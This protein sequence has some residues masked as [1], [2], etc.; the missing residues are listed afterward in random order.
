MMRVLTIAGWEFSK[1]IGSRSFLVATL[2]SPLLFAAI[3]IIPSLYYQ[4]SAASGSRI[5]VVEFD[6]THYFHKLKGHLTSDSSDA[7][8]ILLVLIKLDTSSAIGADIQYLDSLKQQMDSLVAAYEAVNARRRNI[9][10][11]SASRTKRNQLESSY[12]ELI[13]TRE[14]RDLAEIDYQRWKVRIDSMTRAALLQRADELLDSRAVEAYIVIENDRFEKG[15]IEYHSAQPVQFLRAEPLKHALQ[16]MLVE[17]RME[18][19]EMTTSRIEEL[20]KPV[21]IQQIYTEGSVKQEFRFLQT[22]L[23]PLIVV[24]C[25]FL[26]LLTVT[27]FL[28]DSVIVEKN[29][30]ISDFT[31][32]AATIGQ[33]F[34]G[35]LTGMGILGICQILLWM[36]IVLL[37]LASGIIPANEILFLN[38]NNAGIF[39]GYFILAYLLFGALALA[40]AS[41]S[42]TVHDSHQLNQWMR[43]LLLFPLAL[44]L[45]VI[46][47]PDALLTRLLSFIPPFT[48]TFMILRTPLNRPEALDY[49]LSAGILLIAAIVVMLLAVKVFKKGLI[50]HHT[51]KPIQALVHLV[52]SG[53]R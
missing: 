5:G 53:L 38:F 11:R 10:Q 36:L 23:A 40:I 13:T 26:S 45:L 46:Q 1:Y 22:Y 47:Y 16:V 3:L 29:Q 14:K 51:D 31:L 39:L 52:R 42:T 24:T 7:A 30:R 37:L 25:L 6:S 43:Y 44:G 41:L 34:G 8:Q 33:I 27:G 19:A 28:L 21:S 15:E 2:V 32:G 18:K 4:N 20:M 9:F 17:D 35:K 12:E 49:Y 48:P 50:R